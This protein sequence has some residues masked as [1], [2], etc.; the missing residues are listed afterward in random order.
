MTKKLFSLFLVIVLTLMVAAVAVQATNH[1]ERLKQY[2]FQPTKLVA[3]ESAAALRSSSKAGSTISLGV[4]MPG[5]SPGEVVRSNN[6]F[7][8]MSNHSLGRQVGWAK[9]PAIHFSYTFLPNTD[10]TVG[11]TFGYN[12]YDPVSGTWPQTQGAGCLFTAEF[13]R[14]GFVSSTVDPSSGTAVIAGHSRLIA[15]DSLRT[16]VAYDTYSGACYWTTARVPDTA[17]K[18]WISA[19]LAQA[20]WP[21]VGYLVNGNDTVTMTVSTTDVGGDVLV[22][23]RKVG[24]HA[25]GSWVSTIIDTANG[26]SGAIAVSRT[27]KKVAVAYTHLTAEGESRN[28]GSDADIM[29]RYSTD[30][31]ATWSGKINVTHYLPLT[32][33]YRAWLEVSALIDKNDKVRLTWNAW[34]FAADAYATGQA[35]AGWPCKI[36]AWVQ[37]AT[38]STGTISTA[39]NLEWAPGACQGSFNVMNAGK[40]SI[41]ECGSRYYIFWEQFND[42]PAGILNDCANADPAFAA[43]GDIYVAVSDDVTGTTWDKARDVTN[44]RTP[45]CDSLGYGGVCDADEYPS[46]SP[47]GM[48]ESAFTGLT[49]PPGAK[50]DLSGSYSGTNYLHLLWLVDKFPG[51]QAPANDAG[52]MTPNDMKWARFACVPAVATPIIGI[53]PGDISYPVYVK[54]GNSKSMQVI[55]EN[56]GNVTLNITS[57]GKKETAGPAGWLGISTTGPLSIPAGSGNTTTMNVTLNQGGIVNSPG[58]VVMLK[59]LVYYKS[60]SPTPLDSVNLTINVPVADTVIGVYLDTIATTCTKLVVQSNGNFGNGGAGKVNMDYSRTGDCDTNNAKVY[61]Y[62]GSPV[63]LRKL[64]SPDSVIASWS[65]FGD[66]FISSTGFKPVKD[67]SAPIFVHGKDV[68]N[69]AFQKYTTD[70]FVTVDSTVAVELTEYA[71]AGV[72]NADSCNFVI[73]KLQFFS[74]RGTSVSGLTLGEAIDWDVPSD[75]GA[76]NKA[77]VDTTRS[78]VWQQGE[79]KNQIPLPCSPNDKRF[80]GMA[81]VGWHTALDT[82]TR[83][84]IFGGYAATN[85]EFVLVSGG[86]VPRELWTNMQNAGFSAAPNWE[87]MHSVLTFQNNYTLAGNDTLTVYVALATVMNGSLTSVNGVDDNTA[88]SGLKST[89]DKAKAWYPKHIL[90]CC[91][92]PTTG[93][94]DAS[95]GVDISDLSAMVDYLFNSLPFPGSCFTEQDVDKSGSVDISDLQAIIDYLFNSIPLPSC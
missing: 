12:V 82:T 67:G 68:S 25:A 55:I 41:G 13:E 26:I 72:A 58:T 86:F 73:Q 85:R 10:Y 90:T 34:P 59:G 4:N 92:A 7:D 93:D 76:A 75:S 1:P 80:S 35:Q 74:Y 63:V 43:N 87:D 45:G 49:W 21:V 32:R 5:T 48:D 23:N 42:R 27:S 22:L 78:L 94:V 51:G 40:L 8:F 16:T 95:G 39:A 38:P 31:G 2:S 30:A 17:W 56:S 6:Y 46:I 83:T 28:S 70:Q 14:A 52:P 33:G 20:I 11:R 69:P 65:I 66:G 79:N 84:R 64:T 61:L 60:N 53:S 15:A 44:S 36:F 91:T 9:E 50:V 88:L 71:P 37:G 29:Y 57:I 3:D 89:I 54:H 62:D 77:G 19:P 47:Y 81:V 24:T 18:R